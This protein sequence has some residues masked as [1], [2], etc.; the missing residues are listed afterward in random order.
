MSS[1]HQCPAGGQ[2]Q[3]G[4]GSSGGGSELAQEAGHVNTSPEGGPL[5]QAGILAN[6]A[7]EDSEPLGSGRQ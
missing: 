3:G 7:G 4:L 1:P 5:E 6:K 2:L